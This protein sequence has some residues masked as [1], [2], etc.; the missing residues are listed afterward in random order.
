[1]K[2]QAE[3]SRCGA[4][5]DGAALRAGW[6][7]SVDSRVGKSGG[8]GPISGR[9]SRGVLWAAIGAM[10]FAGPMG[11]PISR[12]AD[13]VQDTPKAEVENAAEAK[14]VLGSG[15]GEGE[16]GG[17]GIAI[18]PGSGEKVRIGGDARVA[19]GER[20][21]T[22]VAVFGDGRVEGEVESECVVV[23]GDAYIDGKVGGDCVVVMGSATL[24]PK[25]EIGGECCVVGGKLDRHPEAKLARRPTEVNLGALWN[26]LAPVGCWFKS[27]LLLGRPLPP[28]C[29]VAWAV[30]G[31]HFLIYL[32]VVLLLPKPVEACIKVLD[33]QALPAFLVGLVG[34]L[35]VAPIVAILVASGVGLLILPFVPLVIIA[36]A[37]VG[38]AALL[39]W[40]GVQL[41]HRFNPAAKPIAV[42]AFLAGFVLV[43]LLY[44]VPLLGF[45][46]WGVLLPLGLGA[47]TMAVFAAFRRN[48][49]GNGHAAAIPAVPGAGIA[50][51]GLAAGTGLRMD[52]G[53]LD[54]ALQATL[55]RVG[56]WLRLAATALD[57]LLLC[58]LLPISDRLFLPVWLAY[59][60]GMWTWK[61]TTVGGIICRIRLI[62]LDG[63]PIE[64]GVALIRAL[65]CVL[66]F[67]AV[68]LGF[69][70]AGWSRER[71]AWHDIIAGTTIVRMPR[72]TSLV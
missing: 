60:V 37:F 6:G 14:Q 43:S 56:F 30:V 45:V 49:N 48:G 5:M 28:G 47:A 34:L 64:F 12:G 40:T 41:F 1:M 54:P 32:I 4:V 42:V 33:A 2:E 27:G 57:F 10:L 24:G 15:Q 46:L 62:R 26:V 65:G 71:Q 3:N 55:P 8:S 25:A 67:M 9:F 70:W 17:G 13:A 58:W 22:V 51:G 61:G 44:M 23:F 31:L 39:Q 52:A 68:C 35:L 66:S 69:F 18:D 7:R 63:R 19:A 11:L 36:L 16:G 20:A 50:V 72:G 29:W 38:K 21:T 53:S 59:H